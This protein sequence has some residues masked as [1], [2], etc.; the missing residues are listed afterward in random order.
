MASAVFISRAAFNRQQHWNLSA[1]ASNI[2]VSHVWPGR[3]ILFMR[4]FAHRQWASVY[5]GAV[6]GPS[7]QTKADFQTDLS[8]RARTGF[9]FWI[10][11]AL[12]VFISLTFIPY[13]GIEADEALF[14]GPL[15][16][17]GSDAALRIFHHDFPLMLMSYL[18]TLKTGLYAVIFRVWPPSVWSLRVPVV[19]LGAVSLGLFYQLARE[20]AG[21][22]QAAVAVMLLATDP[23]FL[24][25]NTF[26]W[27]PVALEHALLLGACVLFLGFVW[28]QEQGVEQS[29]R[30][31]W[32]LGGAFFCLGLA[33][34]NKAIFVWALSG[35][36]VGSLAAYWPQIRKS[37]SRRN[38]TIAAAG[39]LAGSAP[40]LLY[41]ARRHGRT[42]SENVHFDL[43]GLSGKW[44]QLRYAL[45]GQSLF[46]FMVAE[47]W[48]PM[49]KAPQDALGRA[50]GWIRDRAGERR[51]SYFYYAA[52]ALLLAV[53]WWRKRRAAHF[54]L[55]FM[56]MSWMLMAL[57]KGAGG[58]AHH[59]VLL[60]PFPILFAAVALDSLPW[61]KFAVAAGAVLILLNLSVLNQYLSQFARNGTAG[62]FTDAI[63][64]LD[65][66]LAESGR[67]FYVLD[68][69]IYEP[70]LM[71]ERGRLPARV[72]I[73]PFASDSP[74]PQESR[75]IRDAFADPGALFVTHVPER[76]V[77]PGI[78]EH[79][80]RDA[81]ETGFRPELLRT[82]ADSNGRPVFQLWTIPGRNR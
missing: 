61:Q 7:S 30:A 38:L 62:M 48:E 51:E 39:F 68:W 17:P 64:P 19:L 74:N 21:L 55:I 16:R 6:T 28:S 31:R 59:V 57:T 36:T 52:G 65:R 78:S 18:G 25:T 44:L 5:T 11:A 3:A 82:I 75:M 58:S 15:Y 43:D 37:L 2:R 60:W 80:K 76:D 63:F 53:P 70:L 77:F 49:P 13:A 54:S 35:L 79:L 42:V 23:I 56:A 1:L 66:A 40:F 20:A 67:T 71:L 24:L 27:G 50:A 4:D 73:D 10:A 46:G 9:P 34:W 33:L 47:E 8:R 81:E 32:Q 26:D 14:A 12:F 45:N 41:N 29:R 69:G 72:L 22:P